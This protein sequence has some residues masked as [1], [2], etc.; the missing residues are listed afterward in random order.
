M[1]DTTR[2]GNSHEASDFLNGTDFTSIDMC[3]T[4]YNWSPVSGGW[5]GWLGGQKA[6]IQNLLEQNFG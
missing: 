4:F 1:G 2:E 5:R 6:Q 3:S